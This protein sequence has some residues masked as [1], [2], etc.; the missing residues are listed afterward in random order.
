MK[1][2][3]HKS[4]SVRPWL[5]GLMMAVLLVAGT[6]GAGAL[7]LWRQD[8]PKDPVRVENN[9]EVPFQYI[10]LFWEGHCLLYKT[11]TSPV[12]Q[13]VFPKALLKDVQAVRL[14]AVTDDQQTLTSGFV[15]LDAEEPLLIEGVNGE[16]L[17]VR[18]AEP[19]DEEMPLPKLPCLDAW[20]VSGDAK[21][22][23]AAYQ[24]GTG[25]NYQ[26]Y[27][28]GRGGHIGASGWT[29]PG[30]KAEASWERGRGPV[31]SWLM[32]NY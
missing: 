22:A 14:L 32:F 23:K 8:I 9:C 5:I 6:L 31:M 25:M 3:Q 7:G 15:P 16:R 4:G 11:D 13:A 24:A 12:R 1:T 17:K 19:A 27:V 20:E 26:I 2:K 21:Q 10:G 28:L 18:N 30:G 29:S